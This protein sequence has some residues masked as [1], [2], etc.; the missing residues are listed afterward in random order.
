MSIKYGLSLLRGRIWDR[1]LI[2]DLRNFFVL[3]LS[4]GVSGAPLLR[5]KVEEEHFRERTLD[6]VLRS[7]VQFSICVTIE[8]VGEEGKFE[9]SCI[10]VGIRGRYDIFTE[11]VKYKT[12]IK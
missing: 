9:I 3:K 1:T 8:Q 4:L 10:D 7:L 11:Y 5:E 12:I 6:Y 2:S